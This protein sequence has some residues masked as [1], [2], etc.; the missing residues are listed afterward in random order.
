MLRKTTEKPGVILEGEQHEWKGF[1]ITNGLRKP[2]SR[3]T[4]IR[5]G[6]KFG[7]VFFDLSGPKQVESKG[8]NWY[9]VRDDRGI[10]LFKMGVFSCATN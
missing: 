5:A 1:S 4:Q 7:R 3:S 9:D 10:R 8:R 2:I 6:K